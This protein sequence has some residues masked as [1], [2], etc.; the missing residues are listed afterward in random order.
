MSKKKRQ[1]RHRCVY[2]CN[3]QGEAVGA[4]LEVKEL[5]TDN[6]LGTLVFHT[7]HDWQGCNTGKWVQ[8]SYFDDTFTNALK[9]ARKLYPEG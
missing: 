4:I 5:H 2:V 1:T 9:M 3:K 8:K 6:L 7:G